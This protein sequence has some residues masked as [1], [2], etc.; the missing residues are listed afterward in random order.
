MQEVLLNNILSIAGC[1][2]SPGARQ[3]V[4]WNAAGA[5]SGVGAPDAVSQAAVLVEG[6]R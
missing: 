4:S 2:T 3:A 5:R 1:R 6:S